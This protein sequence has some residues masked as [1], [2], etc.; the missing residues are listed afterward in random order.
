MT[1]RDILKKRILRELEDPDWENLL[2]KEYS[3]FDII[4]ILAD[5]VQEG[6]FVEKALRVAELY[7]RDPDPVP[8]FDNL[9]E[10]IEK[11]ED[12][13]NIYTIRGE[14]CPGCFKKS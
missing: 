5:L 7:A 14:A 11:G 4:W 2:E 13:N 10:K 3:K 9:N 1:Y 8:G 12:I 6:Q